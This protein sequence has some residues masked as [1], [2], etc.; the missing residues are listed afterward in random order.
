VSASGWAAGEDA[1]AHVFVD[2]LTDVCEVGGADGHHLQRVRRLGVGEDVTAA[3]GTGD[4]RRYVVTDVARGWLQLRADGEVHTEPDPAP[5]VVLALALTKAG[6]DSVAARATELGVAGIVPVQTARSVVKW[7]A[8]KVPAAVTR[9]EAIVRESA[10]QCRR[11]RLP[12]VEPPAT[13]AALATRADLVVADRE[14]VPAREL[15]RPASGTWTVAVGPEGGFSAH[16]L[17]L[18]SERAKLRLGN[19]LLRAQTAPIAAVA[20]LLAEPASG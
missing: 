9:L 5:R 13:I 10:M 7:D 11:A 1:A 6:I 8:A 19:H 14:G 15:P 2:A 16:E 18:M 12:V 20:V 4:W 17:A 3:D